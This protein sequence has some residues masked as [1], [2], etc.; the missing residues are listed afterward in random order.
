MKAWVKFGEINGCLFAGVIIGPFK[1]GLEMF[2]E[3]FLVVKPFANWA[4]GV[5]LEVKIH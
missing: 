4:V 5:F 2:N 3:F 1:L